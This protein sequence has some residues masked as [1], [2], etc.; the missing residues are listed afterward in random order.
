MIETEQTLKAEQALLGA[1]FLEPSTFDEVVS[2][3]DEKD[4]RSESHE[5][6]FRAMKYVHKEKGVTDNLTIVEMLMKFNRIDQAGGMLYISQLSNSAST[7]ANIMYYARI[8]KHKSLKRKG[9]QL[10]TDIHRLVNEDEFDT[11]EEFY[12]L[13]DN[14][15]MAIRPNRTGKMRS[16]AD[17]E[18][19]YANFLD[20][21]E[22]L[23]LTGFPQFDNTFGGIGRGWLY[24]LA[25]RPSVGK[26]AKALQMA[27]NMAHQ[28][29]GE[30]LFWSQEMTFNQ[31]KNRQL[32]NI[33]GVSYNKIRKK[34]LENF[35]K[36]MVMK[37]HR[38][39]ANHPLYVE[40]S[41]GITIDHVRAT[42]KLMQRKHGKIG[43]IFVDYLTRMNIKQEKNQTWSRAVGE[44][45]KRFK[46][47]AQEMD[48]PV[49]LLAQLN[50]EGA[51]GA[52][53][54][55]NLRDSGE[56]E[57]EAD[58][59]EFLWREDDNEDPKGV[60]V[61]STIAKGRDIGISNFKYRFKGWIQRYEDHKEELSYEPNAEGF[62]SHRKSNRRRGKPA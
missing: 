53:G 25:G 60:I 59:V 30:I 39:T 31:L 42:A 36:E 44:V 57:Q 22:D 61:N 5:L 28:R 34:T 4:F 49:I 52:P 55:H 47:L 14:M 13:L 38:E 17:T 35:E 27:L 37:A 18:D 19:E 43:A 41:H 1:I 46:W 54:L 51:E 20:T 3:I 12:Q 26:T 7:A 50:R 23:V 15:T 62:V 6:I 45:A 11:P 21:T 33:T 40:D 10:G 24:I 9:L 56:I 32:S 58:V 16:Y 29:S 8:V 48:C 2:M